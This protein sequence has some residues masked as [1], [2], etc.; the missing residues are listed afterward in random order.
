V[1]A[2]EK[3]LP[4]YAPNM[5]LLFPAFKLRLLPGMLGIACLG[6]IVAGAYGV[7]HDQVT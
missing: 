4:Q 5:N 2:G 1:P 7:L 6:A 3:H